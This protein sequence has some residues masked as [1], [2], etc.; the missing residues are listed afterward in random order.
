TSDGSGR[1]VRTHMMDMPTFQAICDRGRELRIRARTL[2]GYAAGEESINETEGPKRAILEDLR[3]VFGIGEEK[4][5]SEVVCARLAGEHPEAYD[6]WT[7]VDLAGALQP[8]GV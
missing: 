1:I 3:R 2:S 5:H 8:Y 7:P 4:L 6:G